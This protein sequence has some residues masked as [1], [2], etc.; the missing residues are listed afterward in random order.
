MGLDMW[1]RDDIENALRGLWFAGSP[2][3]LSRADGESRAFQMGFRTALSA[4]G[5]TFG[6][7]LGEPG[8]EGGIPEVEVLQPLLHEPHYQFH[9]TPRSRGPAL[10][11][12]ST[13]ES[14][15]PFVRQ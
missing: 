14:S 11:A 12:E 7:A 8:Q 2:A 3:G 6:I 9:T 4:L 15:V 5:L 1:F 10:L 13:L